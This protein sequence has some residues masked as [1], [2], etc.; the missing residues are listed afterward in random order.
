MSS[1][2]SAREGRGLVEDL[3]G[4]RDLAHVVQKGRDLE[5]L[6]ARL[7]DD[8]SSATATASSTTERQWLAV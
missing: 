2:S 5:L 8:S 6:A 4:D 3:L 7:V 1:N